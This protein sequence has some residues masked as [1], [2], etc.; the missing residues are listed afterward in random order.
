MSQVF[1]IL[2]FA[3]ED[4]MQDLGIGNVVT[5]KGGKPLSHHVLFRVTSLPTEHFIGDL[6][7]VDLLSGHSLCKLLLIV[8]QDYIAFL[9]VFGILRHHRVQQFASALATDEQRERQLLLICLLQFSSRQIFEEVINGSGAAALFASTRLRCRTA[10]DN[11]QE[12]IE[13]DH[14]GPIFIYKLHNLLYLLSVF[15][16]SES[17]QGVL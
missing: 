14:F 1:V 3:I 17:N 8:A 13:L 16:E 4:G 15:Y 2:G 6:T 9:A 7:S 12:L 10:L 11:H 5:L